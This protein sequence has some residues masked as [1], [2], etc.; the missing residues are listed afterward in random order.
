MLAAAAAGV[1]IPAS[2]SVQATVEDRGTRQVAGAARPHLGAGL[3]EGRA[4]RL[5]LCRPAAWRNRRDP[6][7][8]LHPSL[9]HQACFAAYCAQNCYAPPP[10]LQEPLAV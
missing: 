6:I 8:C 1:S 7:H 5:D 10:E 2:A 4:G 9:S 3:V